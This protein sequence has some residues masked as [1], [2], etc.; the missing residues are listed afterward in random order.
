MQLYSILSNIFLPTKNCLR[1][2]DLYVF[3]H[4]SL[5]VKRLFDCFSDDTFCLFSAKIYCIGVGWSLTILFSPNLIMCGQ[6]LCV[7]F[8]LFVCLFSVDNLLQTSKRKLLC[9]FVNL[10]VNLLSNIHRFIFSYVNYFPML[11]AM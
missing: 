3:V 9:V 1:M 2:L 8:L 7:C 10:V 4:V 11:I 5:W 6:F